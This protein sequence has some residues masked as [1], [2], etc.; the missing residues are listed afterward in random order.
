MSGNPGGVNATRTELAREFDLDALVQLATAFRDHLGQGTPSTIEFR[1]SIAVLLKH[2]D[3]DFLIARGSEGSP[4][5]Y[6]QLRYRFSAWISGLAA[7]LEDL[8][9]YSGARR[10]GIGFDLVGSVIE[11]AAQRGC[12]VIGLNTNER[13]EAA[14]SLYR[15]LGFSAPERA[16]WRGA[17]QLW[18]EKRIEPLEQKP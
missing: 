14:L 12:R 7:E 8:F 9:V 6:A 3:T 16:L 1:E 15:R 17:R 5:G 11:R 18:L 4:L 2:P 10:Q 13:N